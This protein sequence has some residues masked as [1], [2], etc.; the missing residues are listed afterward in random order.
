VA[1]DDV[2]R[3]RA[4]GVAASMQP[5]HCVSDMELVRRHWATR[6]GRAYAWRSLLEGGALL[7]FGSDAPV[8]SPNPA[9][10][11]AAAVSREH[12]AR[13]GAF[14]PEQRLSLDQ[15]LAAY[16]EGAARLAGWWPAVGS[17]S[18]GA[19]ADLVVWN[20]DLHRLDPSELRLAHPV[21]TVLG[22]RVVHPR[23]AGD[24]NAERAGSA[25]RRRGTGPAG[26][27]A[28]AVSVSRGAA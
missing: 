8:E 27:L 2:P 11:L 5:F 24:R 12:P 18:A 13:P 26:G 22:G 15:A 17:L 28:A 4:L 14:V 7:A 16:T 20:A 6:A 9:E 19:V 10:G 21:F 23:G 3:F 1:L 25:G